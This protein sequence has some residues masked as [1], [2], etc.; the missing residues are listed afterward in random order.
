MS[1]CS[2]CIAGYC[3]ISCGSAR[4]V[5]VV[6]SPVPVSVHPSA[7]ALEFAHV[8]T[9]MG[10]INH[11]YVLVLHYHH[12]PPSSV[13][14]HRERDDI[15]KSTQHV[16]YLFRMCLDVLCPRPFHVLIICGLVGF[17]MLLSLTGSRGDGGPIRSV[18]IKLDFVLGGTGGAGAPGGGRQYRNQAVPQASVHHTALVLAGLWRIPDLKFVG[19]EV[20]MSC[21]SEAVFC[22][23]RGVV[24]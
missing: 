23:E 2:T 6:T 20:K 21:S 9:N 3:V 10:K 18:V 22:S 5:L 16:T 19:L 24:C 11:V 1:S 13:S 12:S 7:R 14:A 17:I 4:T 8:Y 15:W